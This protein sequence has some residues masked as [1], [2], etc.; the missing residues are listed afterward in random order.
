MSGVISTQLR[1]HRDPTK[2]DINRLFFSLP[3]AGACGPLEEGL[4]KV[5][6]SA[7]ITLHGQEDSFV[8]NKSFI[9]VDEI[10]VYFGAGRNP[11]F[12]TT[13]LVLCLVRPQIC[14][15]YH[16]ANYHSSGRAPEFTRGRFC[17]FSHRMAWN[18]NCEAIL[19][20]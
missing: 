3:P 9:L 8:S 11:L 16:P 1:T 6:I 17:S 12:A 10:I 18:E 4:E 5:D 20:K 7:V 19:S 14:T 15:V 2:D 13:V